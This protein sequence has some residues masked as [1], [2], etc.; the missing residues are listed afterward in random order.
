M[1]NLNLYPYKLNYTNSTTS[2]KSIDDKISTVKHCNT[3]VNHITFDNNVSK[4]D[5]Y[6]FIPTDNNKTFEELSMDII[7]NIKYFD[8]KNKLY[9]PSIVDKTLEENQDNYY[10]MI[11]SYYNLKKDNKWGFKIVEKL[12]ILFPKVVSSKH[13]T[14]ERKY[15]SDIENNTFVLYENLP[16]ELYGNVIVDEQSLMFDMDLLTYYAKGKT[17][18]DIINKFN[19]IVSKGYTTPLQMMINPNGSLLPL[20]CDVEYIIA[21]YLSLPSIPVAFVSSSTI[22]KQYIEKYTISPN[23]EKLGEI[24]SPYLIM[25]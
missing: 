11:V 6:E 12:P 17:Q 13:T 5:D 1:I 14:I 24:L 7:D 16:I 9:T 8:D 19:T 23:K 4:F 21:T 2:I 3:K 25:Q 18:E 22:D 10:D 20:G 15:Y